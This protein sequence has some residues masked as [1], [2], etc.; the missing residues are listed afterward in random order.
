VDGTNKIIGMS[1]EEFY[2]ER[3]DLYQRLAKLN[4]SVSILRKDMV[5]AGKARQKLNSA[6]ASARGILAQTQANL[7]R[8]EQS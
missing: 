1:D 2:R 3:A 6:L 4:K 7:R 5:S 8:C